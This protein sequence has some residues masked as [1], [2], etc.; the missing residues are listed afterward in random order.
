ML[1]MMVNGELA[2]IGG[3]TIE[4]V[5]PGALRMRRFYVRPRWRRGGIGRNLAMALLD[6][7]LRS[8][9][10]I[11]VNASRESIPFW[12]ALGFK[13]DARDGHTHLFNVRRP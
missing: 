5:V 11:T 10:P 3:L 7:A 1:T 6:H 4:S 2:G 12:E 9:R 13:P 8:G